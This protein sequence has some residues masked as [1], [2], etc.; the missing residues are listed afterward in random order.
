M[1]LSS[2][3]GNCNVMRSRTGLSV[4]N[5]TLMLFFVFSFLIIA[6]YNIGIETPA[7]SYPSDQWEFLWLKYVED[8]ETLGKYLTKS[9]LSEWNFNFDYGTGEVADT[10]EYENIGLRASRTLTVPSSARY[11]FVLG[12]DDG[13]RL[14]IYTS[15]FEEV[16]HFT[17]GWVDRGYTSRSYDLVLDAGEYKFLLEWYEH[18]D[19][20][21][22]TFNITI[23]D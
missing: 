23:I 6:Y 7:P 1:I 5:T 10:G 17:T 21:Q 19:A 12:S 20:A 18:Y 22:V 2:L 4:R 15:D 13:I 3:L 16:R 9:Y 14:F 8:S 11:R